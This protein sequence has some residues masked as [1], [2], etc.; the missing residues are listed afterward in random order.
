MQKMKVLSRTVQTTIEELLLTHRLIMIMEV[1]TIRI[2]MMESP[3][4]M[5]LQTMEMVMRQI[6]VMMI[7]EPVIIK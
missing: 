5:V 3:V 4:A 1:V 2:T 7:K 6:T